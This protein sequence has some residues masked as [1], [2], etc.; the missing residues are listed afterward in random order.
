MRTATIAAGCPF[1][2]RGFDTA[3][4]QE[5]QHLSDAVVRLDALLGRKRTDSFGYQWSSNG[6]R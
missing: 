6:L 4:N 5:H 3:P 1:G 2:P